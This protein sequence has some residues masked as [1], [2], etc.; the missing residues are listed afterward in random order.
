MGVVWAFVAVVPFAVLAWLCSLFLGNIKL[1]KGSGPDEDGSQN[2]VVEEVYLWTLL[3][4][5]R[6]IQEKEEEKARQESESK[7][8]V[9]MST[10]EGAV[11]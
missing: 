7:R 9:E 2:I 5:R 6:V 1:G 8:T 10:L 4:G 3:Q 11:L